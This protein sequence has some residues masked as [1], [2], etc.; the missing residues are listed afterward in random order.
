MRKRSNRFVYHLRWVE[1]NALPEPKVQAVPKT[2]SKCS[3][4]LTFEDRMAC[5]GMG[6]GFN[7]DLLQFRNINQAS[8]VTS[9]SYCALRNICKKRNMAITKRW[10]NLP[11]VLVG[12]VCSLYEM[13]TSFFNEKEVKSSKYHKT[14]PI[15]I[16]L[17]AM[18]TNSL[19]YC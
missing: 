1:P 2:C 11:F 16:I 10:K 13:R 6:E 7:S 19:S 8:R 9:I 15:P 12:C 18:N 3:R 5:F 17:K 14:P 4:T